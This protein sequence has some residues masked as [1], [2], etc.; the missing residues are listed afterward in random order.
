MAGS[1]LRKDTG[2]KA[3]LYAECG[4]PEYWVV[5]LEANVVEVHTEVAGGRYVRSTRRS[6]GERVT[7]VRFPDVTIAMGDVLRP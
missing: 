6:K 7:L 4:A 5:D 1:S 3:T 2:V